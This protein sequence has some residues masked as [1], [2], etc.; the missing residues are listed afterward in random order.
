MKILA[1][2]GSPHADGNTGTILDLVAEQLGD[3]TFERVNLADH[4]ISGCRAC[5]TCQQVPD[6]PGCAVQDD[7]IALLDKV[8]EADVIIYATPLYMWGIAS[9]LRNFMERH[10]SFVTG[11][12]T[13]DW[14]SLVQDKSAALLVTAGGPEEGNADVVR[15]VFDRFAD[16]GK[17]KNLGTYVVPLC[18]TPDELGEKGEGV[19]RRL[20]ADIAA[21]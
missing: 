14:K 13:G 10:L 11:Y 2:L 12:M 3:H 18:T 20:A 1:L 21:Q 16:Y 4:T 7:A 8:L 5:Y 6:A 17:V 9:W 19:A 15:T